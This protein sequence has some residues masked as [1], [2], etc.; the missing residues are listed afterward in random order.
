MIL[1]NQD[2]STKSA[3]CHH[4]AAAPRLSQWTDVSVYIE[5]YMHTHTFT[6]TSTHTLHILNIS[7]C[8]LDLPIQVECTPTSSI[9]SW[10]ILFLFLLSPFLFGVLFS[11]TDKHDCHHIYLFN[12]SSYIH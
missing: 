4:S 11:E 10:L 2:P 3:H 1:I 5:A 9:P 12:Y 8:I 6:H 7:I